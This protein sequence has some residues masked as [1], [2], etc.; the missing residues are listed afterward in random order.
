MWQIN[1]GRL[2]AQV[3]LDA[4]GRLALSLC[5]GGRTLIESAAL[6]LALQ[7]ADLCRGL[8]FCDSA[9]RPVHESYSLPAG[10]AAVYEN[11]GCETALR[12]T[13]QALTLTLR[14]R[15]LST[16]LA[17]RYEVSGDAQGVTLVREHTRYTLSPDVQTVFAQDLI[18][19]YEGPYLPRVW[20]NM[21]GQEYGMPLLARVGEDGPWL[22]MS[23]AEVLSKEGRWPSSHLHCEQPGVLSIAPAPEDHGT[24]A[25]LPL[26]FA[27]PW[28]IVTVADDL[29]QLVNS[30]LCY[31]VNPP[32][33]LEDQSWIHPAR[34]LWSWWEYE[35]G[36]QLYSESKHYIDYA[37]ALGLEAVVLDCGW[38]ANWVKTLCDY[39]HSRG[40]QLWL[41]TGRQRVDTWETAS[42]YIPLWASWGV[43]GLKIDFFEDDSR[44]VMEVYGMLAGLMAKHRLMINFH[45][46]TKPMGEGRTWPHF[47]TA[48]GIMGMEHYKW[49]DMPNAQHNC[50]VPFTRNVSGPMDYTPL[51]FS[52][53]NRNTT[54]AHQLALPVVFDSGVTHYCASIFYLEPW[55]GTRFIRRTRAHYD[56]VRLLK[57]YPG[58]DVAML[59][60]KGEEYLLGVITTLKQTTTIALDFLPEGTWEAEIYEDGDKDHLLRL[61]TRTV[62]RDDT[63]VL[64]LMENGGAA[65]YIARQLREP[66]GGVQAGWMCDRVQAL[67]LSD[68]RLRGGSEPMRWT[69]DL[70]GVLLCGSAEVTARADEAGLYTLRLTYTSE[71][72]WQ[73]QVRSGVDSVETTMPASRS[74]WDM[75]TQDVVLR[76]EKG[77]NRILLR[78]TGGDEPA[79]ASLRLIDNHPQPTV[80]YPVCGALLGPGAELTEKRDGVWDATGLGGSADLTFPRVTAPE[81]GRYILSIGYC[82][83]ESRDI[84]IEVNG[85]SRIDTYLHSTA[86]W[87]FPTWKNFEEKE[88][89]VELQA[90][91]NEIR[92]FN[93]HGPMSHIRRISLTRD[94]D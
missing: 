93:D 67:S 21:G 66:E 35:N 6:G 61:S 83:G 23:E 90:G 78:R 31:D 44:H 38:D 42:H 76:L 13:A 47:M 39:A 28:R 48:E 94:A 5:E 45:G 14:V 52:N 30:H 55:T 86:G 3:T 15:L 20:E 37:A 17:F 18:P 60:R 32:S 4:Q 68:A 49:S 57:G 1:S 91:E 75:L 64:P 43:D 88:V 34:A 40:V 46:S 19:T 22:L 29:N 72:D 50:T 26:P 62:T 81:A 54:H 24:P 73:L 7:E 74:H 27:S 25:P 85:G 11:D 84:S 10:K 12:F 33:A 59:R 79:L 56:E 51:G 41:W 77:S 82:G 53:A 87:I 80:V 16:G 36:A 2:S 69:S 89:L 9:D 63:L 70:S 92:L 71:R 65:V 58:R 8:A